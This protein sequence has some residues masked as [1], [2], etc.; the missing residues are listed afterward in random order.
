M[1]THRTDHDLD[2][3][4]LARL[5]DAVGWGERAADRGRFE[6]M[7]RASLWV[8]S[9]WEEGELVG[10]GRAIS[11][12]FTSAYLTDVCVRPERQR[13]G[14]AAAMVAELLRGRDHIHFVLRAEPRFQPLYLRLGFE[15]AP[16]MLRR[17]RNK[18]G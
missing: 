9:A 12:G 11:D 16:T 5:F 18:T 6:A 1:I 10:F 8:V 3:E 17:R 7:V 14:I 4:A 15:P 13:R 2:Y